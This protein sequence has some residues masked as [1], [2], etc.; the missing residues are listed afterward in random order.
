MHR[1]RSSV[2]FDIL[3]G[4]HFPSN[5]T[6]K[7]AYLSYFPPPPP[8][9]PGP[10]PARSWTCTSRSASSPSCLFHDETNSSSLHVYTPTTTKDG[11]NDQIRQNVTQTFQQFMNH[12]S[13]SF[14]ESIQTF[15]Q[16][17]FILLILITIFLI[18]LSLV[19]FLLV[20]YIYFK[21]SR[22]SSRSRSNHRE[23]NNSSSN[24]DDS[25][26]TNSSVKN[27]RFYHSLLPY[28]RKHPK[29][30]NLEQ[31]TTQADQNN[32]LRL[33]NHESPIL[34]VTCLK[35]TTDLHLTSDEEAE[36]AL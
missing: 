8:V 1:T 12:S 35:T 6:S 36:E 19:I 9:L 17:Q 20:L 29:R 5:I 22:R 16:N 10:P 18:I 13:P 27:K 34:E 14:Y 2:P 15:I 30:T 32:L 24:N 26:T 28:R 23:A 4:I 31:V 7:L 3:H 33:T 25:R 21:R 11:N